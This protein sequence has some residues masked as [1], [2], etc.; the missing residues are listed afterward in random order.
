MKKYYVSYLDEDDDVRTVWTIAE[1]ERDTIENVKD[2]YRDV[3]L[4]ID[5]F[6]T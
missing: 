5:C 2:E 1:S 6:I 4:V 3:V